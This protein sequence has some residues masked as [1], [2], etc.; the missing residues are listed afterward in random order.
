M[1]IN[2]TVPIPYILT[3]D[4][5][6]FVLFAPKDDITLKFATAKVVSVMIKKIKS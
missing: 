3:F 4:Q 5:L 2:F 1:S 6:T